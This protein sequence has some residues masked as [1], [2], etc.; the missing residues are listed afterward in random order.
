M[1]DCPDRLR[2]AA[3]VLPETEERRERDAVVFVVAG[4]PFARVDA[5]LHVR[6]EDGWDAIDLG[7]DPDWT[8]IED[9]V[10]AAW[11]LAAPR[12]LLEAGGR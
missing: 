5:A 6:G 8:A 4:E 9:R 1:T 10:A 12:R 2:D 3:L 7:G 11:E